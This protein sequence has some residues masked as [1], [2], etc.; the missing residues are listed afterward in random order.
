M[1]PPNVDFQTQAGFTKC[2][3]EL[4]IINQADN[5]LIYLFLSKSHSAIV[6]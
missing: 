1:K 4:D 2:V 5:D 6:F 3:L